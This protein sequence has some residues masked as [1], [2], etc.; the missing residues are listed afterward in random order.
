MIAREVE[1]ETVVVKEEVDIRSLVGD[2]LVVGTSQ[3]SAK[4]R[5]RG[6][7]PSP[8]SQVRA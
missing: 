7:V 4:K 2:N 1:V 5:G 6:V 3:H 8:L